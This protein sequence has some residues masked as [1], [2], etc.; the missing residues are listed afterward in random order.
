MADPATKGKN[1]YDCYFEPIDGHVNQH[2]CKVCNVTRKQDLKQGYSNLI[3]HLKEKHTDYIQ[4]TR[5][6]LARDLN[7]P[8]DAFT[9]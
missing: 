4:K 8:M 1:N 5:Q 3:N 9:C 6:F 7:G 2:R